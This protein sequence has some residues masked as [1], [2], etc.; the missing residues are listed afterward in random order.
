MS[1]ADKTMEDRIVDSYR[2][3]EDMMILVFAQWCV[4]QGLDPL[5]LYEKA[6]PDQAGNERLSRG[7]ALTVP[8]EEAGEIPDSTV[9]GVLSLF[10]NDDLAAVVAEAI[11]LRDR[12]DKS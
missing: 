9:M 7:L 6:Y 5:S 8:K 11:M 4:N 2:Q 12:L 10:G 3:D 1:S